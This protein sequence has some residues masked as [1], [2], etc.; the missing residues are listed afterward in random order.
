M[1]EHTEPTAAIRENMVEQGRAEDLLRH[2]GG[3]K[4]LA[5]LRSAKTLEDEESRCLLRVEEGLAWT[6]G[7]K[8]QDM[9]IPGIDAQERNA[10]V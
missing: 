8:W 2:I 7:R 4:F 10:P 1:K 5:E 9:G 3:T 6:A